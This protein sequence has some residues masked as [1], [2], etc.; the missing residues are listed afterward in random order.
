MARAKSDQLQRSDGKVM[1][2]AGPMTEEEMMSAFGSTNLDFVNP[3]VGQLVNVGSQGSKFDIDGTAFL[4]S[5]VSGVAPRDQL[6]SMLA[7]QMAAV[8]NASMTMA[9]R[10]A[11]VENVAQ[12]DSAVRAL[13]NLTRTYAVQLE[14]LGR[15]RT[16]GQQKMTVEHVT[17]NE[18]GQAII[19]DVT[20]GKPK[21]GQ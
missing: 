16:G 18:G 10:L 19:G 15:Y 4:V 17:V 3:F 11:H 8:H 13:N 12:Q 6:E 21:V 14:A 20:T 1:T 9:R 7:A 2:K 5:V